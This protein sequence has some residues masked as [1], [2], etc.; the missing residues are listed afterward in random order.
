MPLKYALYKNPF[1][2]KEYMATVRP[3]GIATLKN[4]LED[5]AQMS[6]RYS[7]GELDDIFSL[8]LKAVDY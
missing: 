1:R 8:F 3:D 4:V 7:V 2:K 6:R 5:M